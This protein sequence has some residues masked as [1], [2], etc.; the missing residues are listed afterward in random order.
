[1]Q[2]CYSYISTGEFDQG[3]I[4]EKDVVDLE[5]MELIKEIEA[6]DSELLMAYTDRIFSCG[7][8]GPVSIEKKEDIVRS[9]VLHSIVRL[10]PMLQQISSGMKL[11]DL[12]TLV[13]QENDICRQLFVPGSFCKVD[14]DF[15]VQ[16]LSPVFSE[17]G[18]M[19]HQRESTV[20]NFLQ[21][22]V[23]A[24][25]DEEEDEHNSETREE[26]EVNKA[27]KQNNE[28]HI[29]V[30]KFCQWLTGQ[31]HIPL[32][33]AERKHFKIVMEF[34]HDCEVRHGANHT[35]CYP[36]VNACSCSVSFPVAHLRTYAEFKTVL[37]QAIVNGF[38]FS[39]Y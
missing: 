31:S 21:A 14:A 27:E 2:W 33:Y 39:R 23:Q 10:L 11:Y 38:E 13:Q 8:T 7:Y 19:R 6:A 32:S 36:V 35:I 20:V 15:L 22:F 34:D 4:T 16:S 29:T 3:S 9:L 1:M 12:L 5:L 17:I 28:T 25:E 26:D 24:M 18:T 30:G 37:S